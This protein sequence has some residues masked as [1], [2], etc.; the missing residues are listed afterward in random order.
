[1]KIGMNLFLWTDVPEYAKHENLIDLIGKIGFNGVEFPVESMSVDSIAKFAIKCDRLGLDRTAVAVFQPSKY[2]PVSP[3]KTLRQAAVRAIDE[4]S[5][6]TADLGADLLSGPFFQGLGRFS[7][8]PVNAEEW[9]WVLDTLHEACAAADKRGVRIALEPLNRF[10]MYFVNTLAD[11][12][13]F[14]KELGLFNVG[15][16]GDTM[17]SNIEELDLAQSYYEALPELIHVHISESTRGTPGSGHGVPQALFRK[18]KDGGYDGY[19]TIEAF[20]G[21]TTPSMIPALCLWRNPADSAEEIARKGY[22]FIFN[23]IK[24]V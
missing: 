12:K 13:R 7:G 3:N 10:E 18:L 1:M 22:Q 14:V 11:A 21:G 17:H 20:S 15:L 5:A 16:L 24:A 8:S 23:S 19:L 2:D 6:K 4:W 9:K